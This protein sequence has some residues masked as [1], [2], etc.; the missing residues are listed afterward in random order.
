M[1]VNAPAMEPL[2]RQKIATKT[3]V[4]TRAPQ[5]P[6]RDFFTS[7]FVR[8]IKGG[9]IEVNRQDQ[10]VMV[11]CCRKPSGSGGRTSLASHAVRP[12]LGRHRPGLGTSTSSHAVPSV[13]VEAGYD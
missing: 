12:H 3:R 9:S 7:Y 1:L 8:H 10:R 2:L 13:R 5:Y 11:R 6:P 4:A